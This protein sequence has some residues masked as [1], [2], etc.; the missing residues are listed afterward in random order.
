MVEVS[1][2]VNLIGQHDRRDEREQVCAHGGVMSNIENQDRRSENRDADEQ[3]VTV[4]GDEVPT[5]HC[6]RVDVVIAKRGDEL[7]AD[8]PSVG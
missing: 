4:D 3:V 8:Q 7:C 2:L 5:S 6:H 1:P